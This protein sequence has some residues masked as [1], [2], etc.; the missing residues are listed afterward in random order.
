[1]ADGEARIDVLD[2]DSRHFGVKVARLP[3]PDGPED[4]AEGIATAEDAEVRCLTML[5][6]LDRPRLIGAAEAAGF[7]SY[8]VRLEFD[9]TLGDPP[10]AAT[11]LVATEADLPRLEEIAR[12]SFFDSRFYADPNFDDERAAEMYALWV[13]RGIDDDE[14]LLLTDEER[15]GFIVCHFDADGGVGTIDLI[16]VADAARGRGTGSR[17]VEAAESA[18]AERGLGRARVVTQARNIGAQRLYQRRG[19][20]TAAASLWL[21]RWTEER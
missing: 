18:F 21:H 2:W 1:M 13:R 6:E 19:Y 14:R 11:P 16:A 10:A 17:L 15:G 8:D 7:R 9:R 12:T 3:E 4:L 5:V 20:R